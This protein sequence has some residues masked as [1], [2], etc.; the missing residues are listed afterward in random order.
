MLES[1]LQKKIIDYLTKKW[2]LCIKLIKTNLNWIPDLQILTWNWK[3]F[4]IEVKQ[5]NWK[6]SEI[7]K[8]RQK[9]L[10]DLWYNSYIVYWYNDFLKL[11]L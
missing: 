1:V 3:T 4:F 10:I 5:E 8:Y 11:N 2:Y 9:Q 7:Q 6:Q